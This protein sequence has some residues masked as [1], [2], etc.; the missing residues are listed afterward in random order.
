MFVCLIS[1]TSLKKLQLCSN[2]DILAAGTYKKTT[3]IRFGDVMFT[4]FLK[5]LFLV[6][7]RLI[8]VL[9]NDKKQQ[10][11]NTVDSNINHVLFDSLRVRVWQHTRFATW[12]GLEKL[13]SRGGYNLFQGN[14]QK[15]PMLRLRT[16]PAQQPIMPYIVIFIITST[17]VFHETI[18]SQNNKGSHDF[19]DD[20][21]TSCVI[22]LEKFNTFDT[23]K[24]PHSWYA[25]TKL[26]FFFI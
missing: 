19:S 15:I 21:K 22:T 10:L 4:F 5:K 12:W 18:K 16:Q 11:L 25:Q 8:I 14:L 26:S 20:L 13:R 17:Q 9:D 2:N 3:N 6:L 24:Q 1:S 7:D 23:H